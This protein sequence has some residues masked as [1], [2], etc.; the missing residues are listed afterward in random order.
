MLKTSPQC[1]K[2]GVE[3]L[4]FYGQR[5]LQG[6]GTNS[7]ACTPL[8]DWDGARIVDNVIRLGK[9]RW[10]PHLEVAFHRLQNH[11]R[12]LTSPSFTSCLLDQLTRS[13]TLWS[14][15][16]SLG[17]ERESWKPDP[18]IGKLSIVHMAN[19]SFFFS[20]I[21]T[22]LH[23]S[24]PSMAGWL[25]NIYSPLMWQLTSRI[26]RPNITLI[27]ISRVILSISLSL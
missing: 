18:Y 3:S 13:S 19:S 8:E 11:Q 20:F 12:P 16:A 14:T 7:T 25:K 2:R 24:P 23:L 15:L 10:W 6:R 21:A 26:S 22:W 9:E 17:V 1:R 5:I 4:S 27:S